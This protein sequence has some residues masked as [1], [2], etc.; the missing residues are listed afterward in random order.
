MENVRAFTIAHN[1]KEM[2]EDA[3]FYPPDI[4]E[5]DETI[6]MIRDNGFK[7]IFR[8]IQDRADI[9]VYFETVAF[10]KE[11]ELKEIDSDVYNAYLSEPDE[12]NRKEKKVKKVKKKKSKRTYW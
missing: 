2:S 11:L 6:Q 7:I 12:K 10:L 4:V 3:V 5:N 1:V 9:D 8:T